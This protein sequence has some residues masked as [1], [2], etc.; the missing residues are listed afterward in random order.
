VIN[1]NS[2]SSLAVPSLFHKKR[3]AV[4]LCSFDNSDSNKS[5]YLEEKKISY[6]KCILD[7]NILQQCN[8]SSLLKI[9]PIYEHP[10][11]PVITF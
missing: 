7:I 8:R 4:R 2:F 11:L 6:Y 1:R 3:T 10:K 5:S 9:P